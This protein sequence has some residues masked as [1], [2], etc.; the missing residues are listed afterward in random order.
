M[1]SM[2]KR[3]LGAVRRRVRDATVPRAHARD[4]AVRVAVDVVVLET[5]E[6]LA[7]IAE[8]EAREPRWRRPPNSLQVA[9]PVRHARPAV[10]DVLRVVVVF[11]GCARSRTRCCP[12]SASVSMTDAV[13]AERASR[14]RA[15]GHGRCSARC[16]DCGTRTSSFGSRSCRGCR[17][18]TVTRARART[19]AGTRRS[20]RAH[21]TPRARGSDR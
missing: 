7:G 10:A 13:D 20:G 15:C 21:P 12:S 18:G 8:A 9:A 11:A 1:L 6:R 2:P 5:A 17:P 19:P 16:W 3:E 4:A 14:C